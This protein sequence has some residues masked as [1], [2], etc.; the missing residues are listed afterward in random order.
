MRLRDLESRDNYCSHTLYDGKGNY[1][2]V[3]QRSQ[4]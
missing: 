4:A 2:G 1:H 3:T